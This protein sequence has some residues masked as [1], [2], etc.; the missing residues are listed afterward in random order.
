MHTYRQCKIFIKEIREARS[1]DYFVTSVLYPTNRFN[2]MN[3][4][5]PEN[6]KERGKNSCSGSL[7]FSE[8]R[9]LPV[10]ILPSKFDR[11][12]ICVFTKIKHLIRSYTCLNHQNNLL[13]D[14]NSW[15]FGSWTTGGCSKSRPAQWYH[16][17]RSE[18]SGPNPWRRIVIPPNS[19]SFYKFFRGKFIC[20]APP[21]KWHEKLRHSNKKL[22]LRQV[23][24]CSFQQADSE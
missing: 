2:E 17:L 19:I 15:G 6:C 10:Q 7:G 8:G 4:L 14:W 3:I 18:S 22:G 23:M 24:L 9:A 5:P 20:W 1:Q 16:D 13:N 12:K 21:R 11:S